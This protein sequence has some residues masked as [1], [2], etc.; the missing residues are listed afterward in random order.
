MSKRN[1]SFTCICDD[2]FERLSNDSGCADIDECLLPDTCNEPFVTC[3]NVVGGFSCPCESI[4]FERLSPES[5]C[6]DINECEQPNTA[7][8]IDFSGE[9]LNEVGSFRCG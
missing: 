2:G 1:R 3:K 8:G 9:C 6:T 7:C 4:G 5:N